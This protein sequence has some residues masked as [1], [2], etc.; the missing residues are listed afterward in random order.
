VQRAAHEPRA[1][2]RLEDGRFAP[3]PFGEQGG[4]GVDDRLGRGREVERALG[5]LH[6]R[7]RAV[8][9]PPGKLKRGRGLVFLE[10]ER[11]EPG[12]R[13]HRR[14][15]QAAANRSAHAV[16]TDV[17]TLTNRSPKAGDW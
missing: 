13:G 14:S 6:R 11:G 15:V 10:A 1:G 4:V 7:E 12:E 2:L 17:L 8:G 5:E 16:G 9:D 3:G